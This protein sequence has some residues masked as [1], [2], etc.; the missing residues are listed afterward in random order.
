MYQ[1]FSIFNCSIFI[2]GS[3][4]I[5]ISGKHC[6]TATKIV[7]IFFFSFFKTNKDSVFFNTFNLFTRYPL[8]FKD[9]ITAHSRNYV[10][11]F[12]SITTHIPNSLPCSI[13]N[14]ATSKEFFNRFLNSCILVHY[15]DNFSILIFCSR[16]I[17]IYIKDTFTL[18]VFNCFADSFISGKSYTFF[19][20]NIFKFF[21][22]STRR[23]TTEGIHSIII[24]E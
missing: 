21:K 11:I 2:I 16:L 6:S 24:L 22:Y 10:K 3:R 17:S 1:A 23:H 19:T 18:R 13:I 15:M 4:Y 5:F 20:F 12:I 9:S 8:E 14:I 7:S